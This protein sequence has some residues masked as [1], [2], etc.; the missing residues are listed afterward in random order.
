MTIKNDAT[1]WSVTVESSITLLESSIMLPESSSTLL[2]NIV[3]QASLMTVII[4]R[5]YVYSTGHWSA[6]DK[7]KQIK[8]DKCTKNIH[9]L[10][11]LMNTIKLDSLASPLTDKNWLGFKAHL[12]VWFD[13]AFLHF[14]SLTMHLKT[15]LS[16]KPE[17]R[18]STQRKVYEL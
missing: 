18:F 4:W 17:S 9:I 6:I 1:S 12:R 14:M 11:V 3:V 7:Y 5:S 16:A 10:S 15:H 8:T 13:S 2:E